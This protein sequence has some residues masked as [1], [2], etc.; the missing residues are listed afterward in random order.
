[1]IDTG[2]DI[3][4]LDHIDSFYSYLDTG[5]MDTPPAEPLSKAGYFDKSK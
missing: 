4:M 2:V 3:L 5:D 1:M